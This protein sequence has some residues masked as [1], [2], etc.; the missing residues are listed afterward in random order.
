MVNCRE[1][2]RA[3]VENFLTVL[4]NPTFTTFTL[5]LNNHV[6]KDLIITV[7]SLYGNE[8]EK[9][10]LNQNDENITFGNAYEK[11][12]YLLSIKSNSKQNTFIIVKQ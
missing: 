9:L 3:P 5:S 2:E 4:P 10:Y 1:A 12:I 6:D 11:G 7:S 8:V